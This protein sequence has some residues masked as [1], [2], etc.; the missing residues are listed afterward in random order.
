LEWEEIFGE[1]VP[2]GAV[3]PI[4]DMFDYPQVLAGEM[5]ATFENPIVGKY[6]GL[7]NPIKFGATP[8]AQP[9]AAPALGQHTASVLSSHG[10]SADEI[11]RLRQDGSILG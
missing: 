4:E 1:R 8:G 10:Y 9:T 5:V 6:R 7:A 3:R 11:D 2:C